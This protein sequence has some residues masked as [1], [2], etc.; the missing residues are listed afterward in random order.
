MK[1]KIFFLMMIA[2]SVAGMAQ[3]NRFPQYSEQ[4]QA[5]TLNLAD[6]TTLILVNDGEHTLCGNVVFYTFTGTLGGADRMI[7]LSGG[8]QNA[9][10]TNTPPALL[11]RLLQAYQSASVSNIVALYRPQDAASI[12]QTLAVDSV[13]LPFLAF[14]S[15]VDSIEYLM[16]Y[17]EDVY[18]VVITR[19]YY[20]ADSSILM[21][22]MMAQVSGQWKFAAASLGGA[23]ANNLAIFLNDYPPSALVSGNDLDGDGIPNATDNCPCTANANQADSDHDGIGDACDNCPVRYNPLQED[24]DDDGI[25][26]GCDNCPGRYNPLQ[27]DADGDHV[28]DSCDNCPTVVN[29]RQYDFDMDG[30]GDDCDPD[31]DGDSILNEM[32]SDRDGDGVPDSVDNCLIH[33]NPS[34]ADTDGDGIGD[35][36]D[37]CPLHANPQQED[38]DGDGLGDPCDDDLDGDNVPDDIDNCPDTFNPDQG[39]IDC[40][41]IGDACD[42]DIDGDNVPNAQ[43]NNP[44]VFNPEQQ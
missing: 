16:S 36:C 37:N 40:D 35:M 17:N 28:G 22:Y 34:Q 9:S 11:C 24:T 1:Y 43:D 42:P 25:G 32:D 26:D 44:T 18:T 19:L 13:R 30:I 31:I 5:V 21:T 4:S 41:G 23:M 12:N 33:F 27:E 15:S 29:P 14:V 6:D 10:T 2:L 3:T 20:D 39:D 8:S 7:A 38:S